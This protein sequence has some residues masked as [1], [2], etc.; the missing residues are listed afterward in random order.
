MCESICVRAVNTFVIVF[1][2]SINNMKSIV[3]DDEFTVFQKY[4]CVSFSTS[5]L[6][7]GSCVYNVCLCN[8]EKHKK[9]EQDLERHSK[10]LF[11]PCNKGIVHPKKSPKKSFII[12]FSS[13]HSDNVDRLRDDRSIRQF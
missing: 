13:C 3:C 8:R 6:A 5:S 12:Y 7:S 10:V 9:R 4:V 1:S 2:L 11:A